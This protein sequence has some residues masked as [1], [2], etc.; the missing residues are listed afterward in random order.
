MPRRTQLYT[1]VPWNGGINSSVD[2]GVL[3]DNDL[4]Q[5]DNVIF[6]TSGSRLKRQNFLYIDQ[7]FPTLV[8]RS[9]IGLVRSLV[10]TTEITS[11]IPPINEVFAIGEKIIV[12]S[13]DDAESDYIGTF[14]VLSITTTNL[15]NDT[16]NYITEASVTESITPVSTKL[17]IDRAS[18]YLDTRDY[19]RL[20]AQYKKE[21][22]RMAF[23]SQGKLY[24]YDANGRRSEVTSYPERTGIVAVAD[25][26]DSLNGKY[27]K[28]WDRDGSVGVFLS[29]GTGTPPMGVDRTI[30]VSYMTNDSA[31]A[32][33]LAIKTVLDADA[34][35]V[36]LVDTDTVTVDDA[37]AGE[38]DDAVD[39][40]TSF[41]ITTAIQGRSTSIPF[42]EDELTSACSLVFN[43]RFILAM[44]GVGNYPIVYRPEDDVD[45]YF[46]LPGSPPDF[47][48]MSEHL[49]RIF[50]NNKILPDRI[51]YCSTGNQE[52]WQGNGDS[53]AV[54]LSPGDGDPS[55]LTGIS[56]SFK[57]RIIA[58][59]ENR[60]Y[61][62]VGDTPENFQPLPIS[63]GVGLIRHQAIS[64]IDLDDLLYVSRKGVHSIAATQAHGSYTGEFLSKKIQPTFNK[65]PKSEIHKMSSIYIPEINSVAF[66][67]T[68][69]G[70][71]E[72]NAIW[73]YNVELQEW[74]RWPNQSPCCF[75]LM[76]DGDNNRKLVWGTVNSRLV[77]AQNGNFTDFGDTLAIE[78]HLKTG[79]IYPDNNPQTVK[80]FKKLSFLYKPRGR[81][82][83]IVKVKIDNLTVQ[84]FGFT[85]EVIGDQLGVDFIL[86]TSVLGTDFVFSP[87]TV[88]LEGYGRGIEL[89]IINNNK[90]EQVE[91]YGFII[92]YE[93]ADLSQEVV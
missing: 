52:E 14:Y 23:S 2:A 78:Y 33:A 47:S 90:D 87:F 59:K 28:I 63:T 56:P 89:E 31:V 75:A 82:S 15:T 70:E 12:A 83:F 13:D 43:E 93:N 85:Q 3:P 74:Y 24:K 8:S 66:G 36:A 9:S 69:E 51:E 73:L 45:H 72:P 27:F 7:S 39:V 42:G 29:S 26:A 46:P 58:G 37:F 11:A 84:S 57:N 6:A 67:V 61:Q 54:D 62:L 48:F 49:G 68:E 44:S 41:T 65:W 25:V 35:F 4:V 30:E 22:L 80:G 77:Q 1:K 16:L 76:L 55:G 18:R 53:G 64:A 88:P 10:F 50:T 91:L 5:A 19:W 32:I 20:N 60:V 21:Q 40:D 38:R 79:R 92:E 71:Q 81:Y 17:T 34:A 86:G